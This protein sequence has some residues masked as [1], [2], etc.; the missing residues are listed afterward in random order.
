MRNIAKE[1]HG[2]DFRENQIHFFDYFIEH[3]NH[4]IIAD[5]PTGIGKSLIA[6]K[7]PSI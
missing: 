7:L 3:K 2:S 4:N 6:I 1:V 5:A